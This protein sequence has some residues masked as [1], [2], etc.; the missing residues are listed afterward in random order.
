[1]TLSATFWL[2]LGTMWYR[3]STCL[4][5]QPSATI[6]LLSQFGPRV[7]CLFKD[8][9]GKGIWG[10]DYLK[11]VNIST[12]QRPTYSCE[13]RTENGS[14]TPQQQVFPRLFRGLW[15]SK[16]QVLKRIQWP[17]VN[18]DQVFA[19][20]LFLRSTTVSPTLYGYIYVR[21]PMVALLRNR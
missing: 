17:S 4:A 18:R 16:V 5:P 12:K 8:K 11:Y 10:S 21:C 3:E 9:I 19:P 13:V 14:G 1:M 6:E 20:R 2:H 15:T 7:G